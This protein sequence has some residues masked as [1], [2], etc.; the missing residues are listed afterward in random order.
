[1]QHLHPGFGHLHAE[2]AHRPALVCDLM[3]EFHSLAVDALCMSGA[4]FKRSSTH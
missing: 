3:E 2:A 1:L 4:F